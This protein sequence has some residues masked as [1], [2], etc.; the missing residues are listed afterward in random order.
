MA[1]VTAPD[2]T[3]LCTVATPERT[4]TM[5]FTLGPWSHGGL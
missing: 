1:D 3:T 5:A 2:G 4:A